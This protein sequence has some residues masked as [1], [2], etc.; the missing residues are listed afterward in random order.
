MRVNMSHWC[1]FA[2]ENNFSLENLTGI[3]KAIKTSLITADLYGPEIND[4]FKK[5]ARSKTLFDDV[6]PLY[7]KFYSKKNQAKLLENFYGLIPNA[8][9]YLNCPDSN[10]ATINNDRDTRSV[11]WIFQ[12]LPKS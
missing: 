8:N 7:D 11:S 12:S 10:A 9:K 6:L 1:N 2:P 3:V 5:A 4:A